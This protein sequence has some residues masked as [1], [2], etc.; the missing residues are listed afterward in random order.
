MP[1]KVLEARNGVKVSALVVPIQGRSES[2]SSWRD[3]PSP[4]N[5]MDPIRLICA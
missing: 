5:P 1:S 4:T 3:L 2:R